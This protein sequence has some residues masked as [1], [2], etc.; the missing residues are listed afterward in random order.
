MTVGLILAVIAVCYLC[1]R[2]SA[3]WPVLVLIIISSVGNFLAIQ[4]NRELA[5]VNLKELANQIHDLH[6]QINKNE[7]RHANAL[8]FINQSLENQR[9][10][11]KGQERMINALRPQPPPF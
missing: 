4:N 1:F 2:Y 9:K 7:T 11:L 6:D 3:N 10:I 5:E 8:D